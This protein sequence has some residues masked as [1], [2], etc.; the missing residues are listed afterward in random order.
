MTPETLATVHARAFAGQGRAWSAAEFAALMAS[1]LVFVTGDTRGFALGRVIADEAELLT[2]ATDPGHRRQ[3]HARACLSAFAAEAS[4]RG[5]DTA[6]LEV[7]EDNAAALA[8]YDGAGFTQTARRAGY[9]PGGRA[10]VVMRKSLQL[11][12]DPEPRTF[13]NHEI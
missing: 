11:M 4:A 7:A 8:L 9:Y 5:A 1:P 10:A 2:L 6:F 13:G 3:G 12:I